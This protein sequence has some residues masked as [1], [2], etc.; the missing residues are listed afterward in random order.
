MSEFFRV[1]KVS[2]LR[3]GEGKRFLIDDVEVAVFL[4]DGKIFALGNVCPHQKAARIYEGFIEDRK[5]V[6]PLHGWTFNLSDGRQEGNRRGLESYE[7]KVENNEVY[8]KV[9]KKELNW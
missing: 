3:A 8:V 6:C 2:D 7:V 5:V 9:L 4:V 1:C